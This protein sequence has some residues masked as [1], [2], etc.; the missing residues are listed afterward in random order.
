MGDVRAIHALLQGFADQGLL[1]ARSI[2][3]LYDQLRDFIVYDDGSVLDW[4]VP[5]W[6]K[7]KV[8]KSAGSLF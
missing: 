4:S 7:R 2:S 5:V 1:L 8:W 6:M 3:S